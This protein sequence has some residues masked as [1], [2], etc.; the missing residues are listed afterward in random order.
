MQVVRYFICSHTAAL[1]GF[2]FIFARPAQKLNCP[3]QLLTALKLL[4]ADLHLIIR[5][6]QRKLTAQAR[7]AGR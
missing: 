3:V 1:Y 5:L 4:R 7:S 2:A 6:S